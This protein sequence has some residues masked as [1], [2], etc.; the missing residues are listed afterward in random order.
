MDPNG[1]IL[2]ARTLAEIAPI[3]FT[4]HGGHL[5]SFYRGCADEGIEL[6]D[7]RHEAAAVN[8]ADGYARVT[9]GLGV[10]A[11]TSGPGFANGFAGITNAYADGVPLLVVVAAPPLREAETRELQ[12]GIDQIAAL[13]P[14]T[15]WAHRITDP[16]RIPDLVGLAVR[17][18]LSDR[19]GPV[20]LELPIDVAFAPVDPARVR[21]AGRP[22]LGARTGP[23]RRALAGALRALDGAERPVVLAGEGL[24]WSRDRRILIDFAE[25][26]GIPVLSGGPAS[27]GLPPGHPL[28]GR[29][30]ATLAALA[31]SGGATPD[32]VMLLGFTPGM[33]SGGRPGAVIPADAEIVQVDPDAAEIGR[34][35]PVHVAVQ[36]DPAETLAAMLAAHDGPWPARKEWA[37]TLMGASR[38]PD[39]L[40]ADAPDVVNGRIHPHHATREA[41]AAL[42]PGSIVVADGGESLAWTMSAAFSA[43]IDLVVGLGHQGH[44]GVGHGFAI[45]AQRAEPGRRVVQITGDGAVGFHIQEL[46]TMVRHELPIVTVVL[47]NDT[48]GMSIHSQDVLFGA[49]NDIVTRLAPT[50]YE[51]VAEA[52]GAYGEHVE[53]PGEIGPA[54]RRALDSGRPALINV[55]ISNEVVH[56]VTTSM[57]GD[58]TTTDEIV[59]PYYE[60][61]PLR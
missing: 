53:K 27:R 6:L 39:L 14:V 55:A 11:V 54:I 30:V 61:I 7:F 26:S 31:M 38:L 46:D 48:W 40:F 8:A 17:R 43:D 34:L 45:G 2:L 23:G 44:L 36:A 21:P 52:F 12:G 41:L 33:H 29:G 16:A 24:R 60:N 50:R 59:I 5:D 37:E 35:G 47:S 22:D 49:G 58:V 15:K 57:L 9:G 32:V 3:V 42:D 56:P 28:N 18:A 51:K 19:P 4:L 20:A 10:A 13:K 25:A 1:G